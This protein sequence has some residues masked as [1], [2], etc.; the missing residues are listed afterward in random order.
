MSS[1]SYL[2]FVCLMRHA[3]TN[4]F[5]IWLYSFFIYVSNIDFCLIDFIGK[6]GNSFN[7]LWMP[8]FSSAV[9]ELNLIGIG[10]LCIYTCIKSTKERY[11]IEWMRPVNECICIYVFILSF[12]KYKDET[13]CEPRDRVVQSTCNVHIQYLYQFMY[14]C[15]DIVA[16]HNF[17]HNPHILKQKCAYRGSI[18]S[19]QEQ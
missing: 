16:F 4:T 18:I 9:N 11:N 10:H 8:K 6:R 7:T 3:F 12:K 14:V 5:Y 1:S 17:T 15:M 19:A 2:L 13:F